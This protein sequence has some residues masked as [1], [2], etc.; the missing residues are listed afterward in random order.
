MFLERFP[1]THAD[2]SK[3]PLAAALVGH[4]FGLEK[5]EESERWGWKWVGSGK[6]QVKSRKF[7]W[8]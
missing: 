4:Q 7:K 1:T 6:R 8:W 5:Y 2:N 3:L